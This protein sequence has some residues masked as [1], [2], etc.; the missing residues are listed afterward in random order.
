MINIHDTVFQTRV[1]TATVTEQLATSILVPIEAPVG[2][3]IRHTRRT[4]E[5]SRLALK[6]EL[7]TD[8]T[9]EITDNNLKQLVSCI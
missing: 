4:S 8:G 3:E 1:D 9:G 6:R 7:G 5:K 2:A